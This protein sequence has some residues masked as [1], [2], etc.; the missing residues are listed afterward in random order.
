V[1]GTGVDLATIGG[2]T[3]G[4]YQKF[5]VDAYGRIAATFNDT[6]QPADTGLTNITTVSNGG[7]NGFLARTSVGNWAARTFQPGA[8]IGISNG[9]GVSGN[10]TIT[11]TPDTVKQQVAISLGGTLEGTRSQVNFI[12]GTNTTLTVADNA[13]ANRVDVTIA[14]TGGGGGAPSSSEY[15]VLATD[16][17]LSNERTLVVGAGLIIADG[18]SGNNV[19]ISL[20]TDLGTVP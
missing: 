2:L 7:T 5:T 3:P 1:S 4:T 6:W 16:A 20:I 15:V 9:D 19:T 11:A 13:G 17:G 14:A 10:P 12:Q 18:G 8:G